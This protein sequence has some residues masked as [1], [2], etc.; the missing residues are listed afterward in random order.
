MELQSVNAY[1]LISDYLESGLI[2]FVDSNENRWQKERKFKNEIEKCDAIEKNINLIG[3]EIRKHSLKIIEN[4]EIVDVSDR[5]DLKIIESSCNEIYEELNQN[6]RH[7]EE[8]IHNRMHLIELRTILENVTNFGIKQ[9]LNFTMGKTKRL[10]FLTGILKCTDDS[11]KATFLRRCS[12]AQVFTKMIPIGT[13]TNISLYNSEYGFVFVLFFSEEKQREK[14]KTICDGFNSKCYSIPEDSE[15][16]F[17]MMKRVT[18]QIDRMKGIIQTTIDY[19][20]KV[21]GVAAE[22]LRKWEMMV[23]KWKTIYKTM[24]RFSM[25]ED[26]T[27]NCWIEENN[28]ATIN[29]ELA[30]LH[31]KL[32]S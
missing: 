28:M 32:H 6:K 9:D 20:R 30:R 21:L 13:K 11:S 17:Q 27:V 10:E 5:I 18:M 19:R 25:N 7:T 22:N 23:S 2:Q 16:R 3:I 24:D 31:S 15:E 8:L 1:Q 26:N 4:E 14:V 29:S 12:R